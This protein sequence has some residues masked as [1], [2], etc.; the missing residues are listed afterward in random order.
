CLE[1]AFG[2]LQIEPI[3]HPQLLFAT[4]ENLGDALEIDHRLSVRFHQLPFFLMRCPSDSSGEGDETTRVPGPGPS[5]SSKPPAKGGPS[6]IGATL[7]TP[8]FTTNTTWPPLRSAT[9]LDGTT[10]F[11]FSLMA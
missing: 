9:A 7:V 1:R 8:S 6:L 3:E 10:V 2:H 4:E 5:M 11:G